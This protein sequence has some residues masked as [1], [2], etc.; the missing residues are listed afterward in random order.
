[1]LTEAQIEI[2]DE[3]GNVEDRVRIVGTGEV[4]LATTGTSWLQLPSDAPAEIDAIIVLRDG[5]VT[6]EAKKFEALRVDDEF[7]PMAKPRDVQR[8]LVALI[9]A[10]RRHLHVTTV[11][12]PTA[13]LMS[14][15]GA[16]IREQS[17]ELERQA[18]AAAE[19]GIVKVREHLAR[20]RAR[21]VIDEQGRLL[22]P[23][24]K[25]MSPDSKTDV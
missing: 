22:V 1:M 23:F 19:K 18:A 24:P 20:L 21:G 17:S 12:V 14:P 10:V 9:A 8:G 11:E 16:V 15:A 25:D 13:S 7:L 5:A 3:T 4:A 6:I 2:V